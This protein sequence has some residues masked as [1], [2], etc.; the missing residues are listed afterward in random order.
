M[1]RIAVCDDDKS[2]VRVHKEITENCL[3]QCGSIGE[4]AVYSTSGNLLYDITKDEF[5]F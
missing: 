4:I 3:K 1:L 2:A 5:F